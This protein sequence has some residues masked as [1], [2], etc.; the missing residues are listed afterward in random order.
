MVIMTL[1]MMM[2]VVAHDSAACATC[3]PPSPTGAFAAPTEGNDRVTNSHHSHHH[4]QLSSPIVITNGHYRLRRVR[5][6]AHGR[7]PRTRRRQR[8]RNPFSSPT[9]ITDFHH[10]LSLPIA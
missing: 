5:C 6:H 8:S 10:Q 4:H 3:A 9:V 7:L 1:S 2:T